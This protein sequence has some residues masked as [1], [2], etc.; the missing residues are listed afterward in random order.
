MLYTHTHT[1]THTRD[2]NASTNEV[3]RLRLSMRDDYPQSRAACDHVTLGRQNIRIAR[4]RSYIKLKLIKNFCSS[5]KASY[6]QSEVPLYIN[7]TT[8]CKAPWRGD[9]PDTQDNTNT[10]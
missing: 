2:D 3:C 9:Q 1:H 7:G 10:K 6:S 4:H 5:C 8:V